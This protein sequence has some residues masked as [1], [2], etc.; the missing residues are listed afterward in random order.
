MSDKDLKI[1]KKFYID[2]NPNNLNN[3]YFTVPW[4]DSLD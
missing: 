2:G 1:L 4:G 3:N